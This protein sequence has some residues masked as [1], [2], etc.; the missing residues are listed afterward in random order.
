MRRGQLLGFVGM[1]GFTSR[2]RRLAAIR[3]IRRLAPAPS[4]GFAQASILSNRLGIPNEGSP[5]VQPPS[6]QSTAKRGMPRAGQSAQGRGRGTSFVIRL[7]GGLPGLVCG[8]AFGRIGARPA[9]PAAALEGPPRRACG[10]RW[11]R[12][13]GRVELQQ[14][15]QLL[16]RD[17]WGEGGCLTRRRPGVAAR[18]ARGV[19]AVGR[20]HVHFHV[21]RHGDYFAGARRG[22]GHEK[23]ERSYKHASCERSLFGFAGI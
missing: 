1:T 3:G 22:A 10:A 11:A 5:I 15:V 4:H 6:S 17:R 12:G 13:G 18:A 14:V 21:K 20:P 9:G 23:R 19:C 8:P 16:L 2:L 7:S